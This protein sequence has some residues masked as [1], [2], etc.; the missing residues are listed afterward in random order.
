M[1][2]KL[3]LW[4]FKWAVR[5]FRDHPNVIPGHWDD[6]FLPWVAKVLGV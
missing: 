4:A 2:T 6:D 3:A 5:Y 1:K